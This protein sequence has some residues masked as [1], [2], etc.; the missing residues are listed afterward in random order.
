MTDDVHEKFAAN[1]PEVGSDHTHSTEGMT[2][3]EKLVE[4]R[5]LCDIGDFERARPLLYDV[6][7]EGDPSQVEVAMGILKQLDA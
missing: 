2:A 1:E 6:L 4:I 5:E 7:S 3:Q